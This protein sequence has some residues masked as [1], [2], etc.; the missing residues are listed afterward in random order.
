MQWGQSFAVIFPELNHVLGVYL[1]VVVLMEYTISTHF[2]VV[3]PVQMLQVSCTVVFSWFA[4][5]VLISRAFFLPVVCPRFPSWWRHA[6]TMS[7]RP[8]AFQQWWLR[9]KLDRAAPTLPPARL[10]RI[11]WVLAV[12]SRLVHTAAK[13]DYPLLLRHHSAQ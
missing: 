2:P 12:R 6:S 3:E 13:A 9:M 7:S 1:D 8:Q 10:E 11:R 4:T 5:S